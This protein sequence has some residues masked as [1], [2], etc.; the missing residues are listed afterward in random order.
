[1]SLSLSDH[2][3]TNILKR[4]SQ[5][6]GLLSTSH[7]V[8]MHWH[9]EWDTSLRTTIRSSAKYTQLETVW[10]TD[11][12]AIMF[13]QILRRQPVLRS[14]L[15][16]VE[17][18]GDGDGRR[19][20]KQDVIWIERAVQKTRRMQKQKRVG[21]IFAFFLWLCDWEAVRLIVIAVN[22]KSSTCVEDKPHCSLSTRV[23]LR[24]LTSQLGIRGPREPTQ[25]S[26][27]D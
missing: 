14:Y 22:E 18:K 26:N 17:S 27:F 20:E 12:K 21:G 8:F 13:R 7:A 11:I 16:S 15:L 23:V 10:V 9:V 25:C 24:R 3:Y 5:N 2:L 1:M 6:H 4:L 19:R